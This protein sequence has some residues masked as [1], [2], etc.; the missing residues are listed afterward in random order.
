MLKYAVTLDRAQRL[1]LQRFVR[2]G[3][4]RAGDWIY[5]RILLLT[6]RGPKGPRRTDGWVADALGVA[7]NTA[8]RVRQRFVR[9]G[10][11]ACLVRDPSTRST[12]QKLFDPK[13]K[14]AI[15]SM[16]HTPPKDHG[17]NRTTWRRKDLHTALVRNGVEIGKNYLDLIIRNAGYRVRHT[18]TVLTS[19]DPQYRQK[20]DAILGILKRLKPDER[21]FS[22]D[23]FGPVAVK[24]HGGRRLLGRGEHATVPQF[25][26][27]KG[28]LLITAALELSTNQVTHFYST[29]KNTQEMIKLLDVLLRQ[30][31]R[32]RTPDLSWDAA[33]WHAS[34]AFMARVAEVNSAAFRKTRHTPLVRLAPL[35]ARAQFLN[36]IESVFSGLSASII[37]NSDYTSLDEAKAAVDRHFADRNRHFRKHP[38]RAGDKIWGRERV[39]P[40]FREGQNCR[41][42]RYR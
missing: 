30:Y 31:R 36:V 14:D 22:I 17:F 11:D 13:Y 41:N 6:D 25:Q 33:G 2:W 29:G 19:N 8:R 27:S 7:K 5:A 37:E 20:V 3:T 42:P 4:G 23:E 26:R 21:F 10:L 28:T 35:P 18:K 34:K 40:A 39:P 38:K 12:N 15:F 9:R 16:L 32:C 1:R 24:Q